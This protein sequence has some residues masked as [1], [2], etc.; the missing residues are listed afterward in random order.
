M[1]DKRV[2][3]DE[4]MAGIADGATVL[5]G[6]F[7][8]SGEPVELLEALA[9][10]GVTDLVVVAN[11]GGAGHFGLAKLIEEGRVRK[12]ICSYPR[13]PGSV[14]VHELYRTGALELEVVPQGTL[15]ERIRAGGAGIAAFYTPTSAGTL[16]GAGKEERVFNGRQHVLEYGLRA[17]VALVKAQAADRWG[18]LTYHLAARNYNPVM[19]TAAGLTIAQVD[20]IVPLGGIAPEA[21]ITPSLFV[22]RVVHV[23][24]TA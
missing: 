24:R 11:N 23:E 16:L 3:L 12:L 5:A 18:N 9:R 2:P 13:T 17:D 4:A 1:I 14:V 7:G 20:R 22:D 10:S 15:V 21:V 8:N 19:A 6:G